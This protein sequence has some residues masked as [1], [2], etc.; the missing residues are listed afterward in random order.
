MDAIDGFPEAKRGAIVESP[1][2]SGWQFEHA[3][4]PMGHSGAQP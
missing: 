3:R 2:H 4:N 1:P